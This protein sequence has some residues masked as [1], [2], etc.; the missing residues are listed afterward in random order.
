[1]F[2]VSTYYYVSLPLIGVCFSVDKNNDFVVDC[3]TDYSSHWTNN[4]I[5]L[6]LQGLEESS[7]SDN[8]GEKGTTVEVC[9]PVDFFFWCNVSLQKGIF[10][11]S[12]G[13]I[14]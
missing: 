1:M 11:Y 8:A 10:M 4:S 6:D 9:S 3:F 5:L 2:Y 7:P 14:S 13:E 12:N